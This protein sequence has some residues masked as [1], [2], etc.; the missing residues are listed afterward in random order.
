MRARAAWLTLLVLAVGG[1]AEPGEAGAVQADAAETGGRAAQQAPPGT[2]D[3]QAAPIPLSGTET[4]DDW[5]ILEERIRWAREQGVDTLPIGER[6]AALGRT[7]V[8]DPY[9][10]GTLEVAEP[11]ALVVN[12]REF[13][14]V[15]FVESSLALARVLGSTP[16]SVT[17]PAALKQRFIRE[18]TG[19]RYRSGS[20]NG[21][22][23]R[24]H[25]FSEWILDNEKRGHVRQVSAELGG[26]EDRE[27]IRFMSS[28][29]DAY[30]QMADPAVREAIA[31]IEPELPSRIWIPKARIAEIADRIQDGDIIAATST[32]DGL[33]VAH[34]GIALWVG[35]ELH[36]MHA[37]LVGKSVEI[38]EL[39][40]A[41]RI[42]GIR[43]QDGIMVVRPLEVG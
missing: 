28:H 16:R 15:T 13:D 11:E 31:R 2:G 33:D 24:L 37:P 29:P 36:L 42:R 25:Y 26:V 8:G 10:P 14:C 40:L 21:Y 35:G 34:T 4:P 18:L 20:P 30:R 19:L 27:P 39:P 1:C 38:S 7:F 23:S 9:T 22:A 3:Q 6:V 32:L 5:R 43:S 12:L 17:D 41:E